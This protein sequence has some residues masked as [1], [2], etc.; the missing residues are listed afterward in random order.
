MTSED[1]SGTTDDDSVDTQFR[2]LMEG[3]RTSLPGVQVL[4][5]FLLTAPLQSAFG[6]LDRLQRTM[7]GIAFYASAA[8]SLLLIAPSVHQRVRAPQT[9]LRRHSKRH[10]IITTWI[11]IGGTL[12][13]GVAI[14]ATVHLVS[15]LAYGD[16]TALA[17]AGAAGVVTLWAWVYVPLVTFRR[18][19]RS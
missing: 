12:F 15:S 6:D 8:A 17:A 2:S 19:V 11:T 16:G 3:L 14:T 13:M 4:F 1:S 5:A 9:G 10:L 18:S 7:F